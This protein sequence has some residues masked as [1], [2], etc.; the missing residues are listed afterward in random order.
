MIVRKTRSGTLLV[1]P[2][3][4]DAFAGSYRYLEGIHM[5]SASVI[6]SILIYRDIL[7]L[8]VLALPHS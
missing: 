6:D 5:Y 4:T 7:C 1:W 3:F 2:E 8:S